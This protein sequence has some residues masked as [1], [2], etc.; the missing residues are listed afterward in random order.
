MTTAVATAAESRHRSTGPG[1]RVEAAIARCAF[2]QVWKG[3]VVWAI[4]FGATVAAT[5]LSYVNSFPDQASREQL[6]AS[7]SGDAGISI[8]LGPVSAIDTVGGYTVYKCFVFLTTIGAI[9]GLLAATRLLRGEEDAGRW[10]LVLAGATRAPRATG[11]TLAALGVAVAVVFGGT[12]L[13][14]LL[15]AADPDVGFGTGESVFF[16]LSIAVAP[17]VFVAVGALTSQLGRTRR[18]ATTLGM[19][20]FGVAFVVRMLADSGS[21]TRWLLWLSPFGWIERMRPLTDNDPRPLVLAAVTVV[22]LVAASV[23][24]AARRDVGAGTLASRDVVPPRRFGLGTPW[25]L[26]VRLELPVLVGWFVGAA[27]AGFAFGIIAKVATGNVPSSISDTLDKFG[28]RGSF[29]E[30]YLGVAFLLIATVIALMPASQIG[31]AADEETSG[32]LVHLLVGPVRRAPVLAHRL[33]LAAL[34]VVGAALAAGLGVWAGAETQGVRI[35]LDTMIAAALNVVPTALLVLGIG[36]VVLAL[37][38]RLASPAV[39]AVVIS[40]VLV[41]LLGS[42]IS[43]LGG[44]G[45]LS[46]FDSMA[47]APAEDPNATTIVITVLAAVAL[48]IVATLIFDRR[49]VETG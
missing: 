13:C 23:V 16:A 12:T 4:A 47:L 10:S 17:A 33:A 11:A 21:S 43:G 42:M 49:D 15:V 26:A 22:V 46:L 14:T 18:V 2:R 39:Y 5:A 48:C 36:A 38:P 9:W 24:L 31:A 41:D 8:L 27:G 30:Q 45:H 35:D 37:A 28:V 3:A 44:L 40:S 32:R 19:V 1:A 29:L 7:T 20:V 34:A 6:A 25:G